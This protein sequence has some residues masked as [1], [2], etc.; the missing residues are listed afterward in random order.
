VPTGDFLDSYLPYLLRQADQ[1]L[2]AGFY[3]ALNLHGVQRSEWRVIAVLH[4][5]GSLSMRE[6]T[7]TAL[8]P[9]PTVTHAVSRLEQRGLAQ[10]LRGSDDRRQRFVSLTPAGREL[11]EALITD[12]RRLEVEVLERSEAGDLTDLLDSLR[13]LHVKLD[14]ARD[15]AHV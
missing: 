6:L 4:E 11:A 5:R 9:Q 7:T 2:S 14:R 12:A 15:H 3:E 8:S 13:M 10:R 1:A